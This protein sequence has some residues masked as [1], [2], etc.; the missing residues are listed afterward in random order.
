MDLLLNR[1]AI[2][3]IRLPL[4]W[5]ACVL[6]MGTV[7]SLLLCLTMRGWER[8]ELAQR[9]GDVTREQVEKLQVSMLRSL[10]VL[11][12]IASLHAAEGAIG[13]E[14]FSKF[15]RQA[16]ARQPELQALSW[17]PLVPAARRS[18]F[19]AA[20]VAEGSAGF[21]FR[22][23]DVGG[24]FVPAGAR[25]EYV[26]VYFIEPLER[27]ALALGYDLDSDPRRRVSLEQARDTG[28]PAAT[29]PLR[30]AQ[31]PG[32]QTGLLVLMPVYHGAAPA[33]VAFRRGRLA[34]FAVAVFRVADLVGNAFQ[35]LR[36]KGIEAQ[37]FDESPAGQL[38]FNSAVG[39]KNMTAASAQTALEFAGRRWAVVFAPTA[40]FS[41]TQSHLQSRL[42][43][44]GGLAFTL[45][46][47][48]YLF[49]SWRRTR[50]VAFANAALQEEVKVRQQAEAAAAAAN[51]AKSDFLASMSH[52]IRTPLNAILGY[53]QLM[54]RDERLP[55]EQHD[56]IR[57]IS[58]S[59]HHLLGLLNEIL[60]LS[61]IE[62]GRM[63]LNPVDFDLAALGRGLAATF[64]PLC[65]QKRVGFRVMSDGP[66]R[67]PVRGDEGKLRQVLINLLGNAVKFTRMGEVCLHFRPQPED[68]W[69]FEVIDSG[70]GIPDSELTDIFKPFHQ[71]S[72]AR[73]HGGT[74]LGLAIAQRQVELLGGKLE[75]QSSRGV[76]SRFYF[77]IPLASA[78]LVA[79]AAA[80]QVA[81][82]AAGYR[83]R[84]LVVDDRRENRDVLGGLLTAI[85]CEVR[86]AL[87]GEE[88]CC[89]VRAEPPDIIFLDL[90]LPGQSGAEI[91]RRLIAEAPLNPPKIVAHTASA[92]ARHR[93]EA[94]AAGCIDFIAKPFRGERIY[95]CLQVYLGTEFEFA[96]PIGAVTELASPENL[97]VTLPDE[98]S[99]RLNVAAELHSTTALKACLQEL[100]QRGPEAEMLA[101][102]I[103]YRM[104]SYDM[105]GILRLLARVT[106]PEGTGVPTSL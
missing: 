53:A 63:E 92:L 2:S 105:D 7:L 3:P 44:F 6:G 29:A 90:L 68:R 87:D 55:P 65:A 56:S 79:E 82:L 50:E 80:P 17:N 35:D 36:A 28:L 10:E 104:R 98:L 95:E 8:R 100:R 19:E 51:A 9:A 15:V 93:D 54:R 34:G 101:E 72:A 5:I 91:A 103:R 32:D 21:Q 71:G 58:A 52:E 49:G 62:A 48:A 31:E 38:I 16:L 66:A 26:P 96:A 13:R 85:G 20:A 102:H 99:A 70:Q 78:E 84:A 67:L 89:A 30:L 60:D 43:L 81:R 1:V 73:D 61:K 42:A 74:G 24:H 77:A 46:T 22:E 88:T 18:E 83:V 23:R 97:R 11:H 25:A 64:Q 40:E 41:A 33:E 39:Q 37:L 86:F 45:L 106:Q 94:L 75:L 12:S 76:G 27:N 69:M 57:G 4:P 14:R 47:T 59:G